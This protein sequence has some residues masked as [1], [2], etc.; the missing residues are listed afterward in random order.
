M[1]PRRGNHSNTE[2]SAAS[3]REL[4]K[5]CKAMVIGLE[6]AHRERDDHD[7]RVM[8]I[9]LQKLQI[10][11]LSRVVGRE[12]VSVEIVEDDRLAGL[13]DEAAAVA[14]GTPAEPG[15]NGKGR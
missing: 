10:E 1:G 11:L 8:L 14:A 7:H 15:A 4:A 6:L 2:L 13:V 9:R 12:R 5:Q 3:D